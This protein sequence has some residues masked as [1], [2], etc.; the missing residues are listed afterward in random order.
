MRIGVHLFGAD[1][2]NSPPAMA[3]SRHGVVGNLIGFNTVY[4][5]GQNRPEDI[6]AAV[7]SDSIDIAM[8]WG[9]IAGY[10]A[11]R[12]GAGRWARAG[13]VLP[14]ARA[15]ASRRGRSGDMGMP[16]SLHGPGRGP[17]PR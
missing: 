12:I 14:R 11:K 6:I 3:L 17:L 13:V 10:Y 15:R 7:E 2:E 4:V 1:G 5:G 9:P 16:S 8:V